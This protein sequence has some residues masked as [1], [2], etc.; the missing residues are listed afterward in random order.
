MLLSQTIRFK[1]CFY[2][3]EL[4]RLIVCIDFYSIFRGSLPPLTIFL[5]VNKANTKPQL[6][7]FTSQKVKINHRKGYLHDPFR[8]T[9]CSS[10]FQ[11]FI[12]VYFLLFKSHP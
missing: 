1:S 12:Q 6:F 3:Y 8:D 4:G 7:L 11:F 9:V 5:I 2:G 10:F